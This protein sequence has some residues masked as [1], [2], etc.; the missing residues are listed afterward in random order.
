MLKHIL[1]C[2]LAGCAVVSCFP[3]GACSSDPGFVE[4]CGATDD[5]NQP[6]QG[7]ILDAT[8][9][10]SGP[11]NGTWLNFSREKTILMHFRDAQTGQ[12]LSGNFAW[13]DVAINVASSLDA[14][15]NQY[16]PSAGNPSEINPL[17][18]GSGVFVR[19]DT[20]TDTFIYVY[21]T[22]FPNGSAPADAGT[23]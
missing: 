7:K 16:V 14:S 4:Y 22:V 15:P 21:A 11:I 6:C 2:A 20:C 12:T 19:N 3:Q 5:P 1:A 18:D 17:L 9:W 10:Q 13:A 8:H 23:E